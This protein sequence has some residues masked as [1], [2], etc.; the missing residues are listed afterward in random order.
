MYD[1]GILDADLVLF[2]GNGVGNM[3]M[4][5]ALNVLFCFEKRFHAAGCEMLV[6]IRE[7]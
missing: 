4:I 1:I 6:T 5:S 7:S 2:V 3:E